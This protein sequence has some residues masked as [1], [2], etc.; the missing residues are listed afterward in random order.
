MALCLRR[1]SCLVAFGGRPPTVV[2]RLPPT[3]SILPFPQ[4]LATIL[5]GIAIGL[6]AAALQLSVD[7][8]T[9]HRNRALAAL[10]AA[11]DLQH[12][13]LALLGASAAAVLGAT[14]LVHCWAPRA[15][16]GG[17]ALVR[18][19]GGGSERGPATGCS[20]APRCRLLLRPLV[21]AL[22]ACLAHTVASPSSSSYAIGHG[23]PQ[24]QCD[25]SPAVGQSLLCQA[26]WHRSLA[27]CRPGT[28]H[29]RWVGAAGAAAKRFRGGVM[30]KAGTGGQAGH[31]PAGTFRSGACACHCCACWQPACTHRLC[32]PCVPLAR[33]AGPMIHLGASVASIVCHSEH[34]ARPESGEV[35]VPD[36]SA[37]PQLAGACLPPAAAPA[38]VLIPRVILPCYARLPTTSVVYRWLNLHRRGRLG[39][40]EQQALAAGLVP[41][42][43][44]DFLFRYSRA[45]RMSCEPGCLPACVWRGAGTAWPDCRAPALCCWTF[46]SL[47]PRPHTHRNADHREL[48]SAGAAAGL[49]AAFGAPIGGA[50]VGI[51]G[52]QRARAALPE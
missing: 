22:H 42:G 23:L 44:E 49:A 41:E 16:G 47:C 38:C 5:S 34:G 6:T 48:V 2:S 40:L 10:L 13:L 45:G 21:S 14:L 51:T 29:R 46:D 18:G 3:T 17:V 32:C 28:G 37:A 35:V 12:A 11:A 31:W 27:V 52:R 36:K 39:E 4:V 50:C 24:W 15:A 19:G 25:P 30:R 9:H 20:V 33:P 8:S 1:Y 43:A 7:W 26:A